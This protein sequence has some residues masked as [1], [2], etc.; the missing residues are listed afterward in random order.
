[1]L[2]AMPLLLASAVF[3][4]DPVHGDYGKSDLKH[5][6]IMTFNIQ[7]GIGVGVSTTPA[8]A[9]HSGAQ[10]G[11]DYIGRICHAFNPDVICMQ[12]VEPSTDFNQTLA[13]CQQWADTYFGAG[14]MN[15]HVST[16]TDGF[17]RNVT[18]SKFP[19]G[20]LNG[21]GVSM[22][23]NTGFILPGT[24]G[25]PP[26]G[27]AG[28]RGWVMSEINLP[29]NIY[30]GDLFVGN[31]HL[32]AGSDTT[33]YADRLK[34]AQ[35]MSYYI[36]EALNKSQN[37]GGDPANRIISQPPNPLGPTTPVVLC[38]DFNEDEQTNGRDGPVLW[39]TSFTTAAND[40]TD[41][42]GSTM[43]IDVSYK[44][45]TASERGTISNTTKFDYILAQDS[46]A[47]VVRSFIYDAARTGSNPYP[48][49]LQGIQT[50]FQ[51][52]AYA[53]DHRPVIM[54][55]ALPL[56]PPIPGD[57]DEDGD[58]DIADFSTC[59]EPCLLGPDQAASPSCVAD[60][61]IVS[62]NVVDLHDFAAFQLN[63]AP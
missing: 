36:N 37:T 56:A 3:A 8:D 4:F 31:S 57:C 53:S 12:E 39:L 2:L 32:K 38:G 41:R 44:L 24:G 9:T 28:I 26:G 51:A 18:F 34:A 48:P 33:D 30:Q 14:V 23:S 10:Y 13:I 6:R 43:P 22:S 54:D 1:V 15:V 21:D 49:D 42:D 5:V 17:N 61:D 59:F 47:T 40:G 7:D 46:I 20:D 29:D 27:D 63:F 60:A 50:P 55:L 45:F 62:D 11:F 16:N 35:N 52:S 58:V 19:Y 25:T